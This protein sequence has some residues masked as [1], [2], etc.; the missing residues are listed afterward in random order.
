MNAKKYHA[1]ADCE[2]GGGGGLIWTLPLALLIIKS[3]D[4]GLI[5][6][7]NHAKKASLL[8]KSE[9]CSN[10]GIKEK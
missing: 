10:D 5:I 8:T 7:I 3:G 4:L 1:K 9:I 2:F 6:A